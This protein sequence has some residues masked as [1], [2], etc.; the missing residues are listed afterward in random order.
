M[1]A[2]ELCIMNEREERK[3]REETYNRKEVNLFYIEGST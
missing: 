2:K 3:I 1:I